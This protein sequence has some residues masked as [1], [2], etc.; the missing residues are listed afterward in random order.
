MTRKKKQAG[1][2]LI[3][4]KLE[5]FG[6]FVKE[7]TEESDRATAI[8]VG[9]F[10]DEKLREL[11]TTFLVEDKKVIKELLDPNMAYAPISSF[12]SRIKVAYC[13]GLIGKDEYND[14][15]T[16]RKIRNAF[17]HQLHGLTFKSEP[18]KKLFSDFQIIRQLPQDIGS[19]YDNSPRDQ[20]IVSTLLLLQLVD[21]RQQSAM[22]QRRV[23]AHRI[24]FK[25]SDV[26]ENG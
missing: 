17:A 21:K 14:F 1:D 11:I 10:L 22:E 6:G 20:F 8:L 26:Q 4:S 16:F 5:D 19:I 9:A 12:A 3:N 24:F 15:Q 2:L 7:F 23:V 25:L 18:I 13:L